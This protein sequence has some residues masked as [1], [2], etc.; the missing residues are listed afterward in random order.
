LLQLRFVRH[1]DIEAAHGRD[2]RPIVLQSEPVSISRETSFER[3]LHAV[4]DKAELSAIFTRLCEQVAEDLQRKGYA[5]KTIGI[6]LRYDDF[7]SVT[8]DPTLDTY[9]ADV[10]TI[11]HTAGLCLKRAPL[12]QRPLGVRVASLAKSDN[13]GKFLS[14]RLDAAADNGLTATYLVANSSSV[15]TFFRGERADL[16]RNPDLN[17]LRVA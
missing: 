13:T 8:R 17:L 5:G 16:A 12:Q 14:N 3:D 6:K 1:L 10:K 9:T 4:R 7:K 15:P 11:G 2:E